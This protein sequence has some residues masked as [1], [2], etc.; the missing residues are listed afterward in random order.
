MSCTHA[1]HPFTDGAHPSNAD[2]ATINGWNLLVG[3]VIGGIGCGPATNP[4]KY[5]TCPSGWVLDS[6]DNNGCYYCDDDRGFRCQN[7]GPGSITGW[8]IKC[9][10][11]SYTGD[12]NTCATIGVDQNGYCNPSYLTNNLTS[13]NG[14]LDQYM[15]PYC[16][17]NNCVN[18]SA[19][20]CQAWLTARGSAPGS[21]S[22]QAAWI[23]YCTIGDNFVTS[24]CQS[25]A[26]QNP[27][28]LDAVAINYC[29]M[30]QSNGDSTFD[31]TFCACQNLPSILT[32]TDSPL[33]KLAL[34][35]SC[36]LQACASG[37]T[38]AYRT[39]QQIA[40]AQTCPVLQ[41]CNQNITVGSIT[42]SSA[43]AIYNSCVINGEINP[44]TTT[45][46]KTTTTSNG[47]K[48][49]LGIII[50]VIIMG[51]IGLIVQRFS[52]KSSPQPY[53]NQAR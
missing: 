35:P 48:Y 26:N 6:R 22:G 38:G 53:R 31:S 39:A 23:Q 10:L 51:L 52:F 18:W 20:T 37:T 15:F 47:F 28:V 7:C 43:V 24:P 30:L 19:N 50:L 25:Y 4:E 32:Q 27:G 13:S 11:Q 45:S 46:P 5:I 14:G 1:D 9:R 8:A 21:S 34:K 36:Y 29:H 40:D 41:I 42:E 44:D 3:T 17:Q 16:T 49:G 2:I 12:P 33:N